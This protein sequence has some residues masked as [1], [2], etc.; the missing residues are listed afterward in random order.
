M[1]TRAR[2]IDLLYR[3]SIIERSHSIY[4]RVF[5]SFI[6]RIFSFT[7]RNLYLASSS[8]IRN[9]VLHLRCTTMNLRRV[10]LISSFNACTRIYPYVLHLSPSEFNIVVV[11]A[12]VE[13]TM[14]RQLH[15]IDRFIFLI[16]L[17]ETF[18]TR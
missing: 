10:F 15:E 14:R 4:E 6:A 17:S 3:V 1:S 18:T 16:H 11:V 8:S 13:F 7:S 2:V 5:Y 9:A 12:S